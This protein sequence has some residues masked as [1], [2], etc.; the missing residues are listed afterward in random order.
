MKAQIKLLKQGGK[1]SS[2]RNQQDPLH[3]DTNSEAA[4]VN[5]VNYYEGYA[6]I[7]SFKDNP[8]DN[9]L[10][11][12]IVTRNK[13]KGSAKFMKIMGLVTYAAHT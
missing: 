2:S 7:L 1:L 11:K 13:H 5:Y 4:Q 9:S 6:P 12:T 3:E 8:Y 10:F